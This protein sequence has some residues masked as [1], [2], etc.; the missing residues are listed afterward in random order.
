MNKLAN[1]QLDNIIDIIKIIDK[2]K[3]FPAI[4]KLDTDLQ[5]DKNKLESLVSRGMPIDI[6]D[7]FNDCVNSIFDYFVEFGYSKENFVSLDGVET[8]TT[9]TRYI[10][11]ALGLFV[12]KNIVINYSY[13]EFDNN[14]KLIGIK[15]DKVN[16]LKHIIIHETLHRLST[17]KKDKEL[18]MQYDAVSEGFTDTLAHLITKDYNIVSKSYDFLNRIC[19][20]FIEMIGLPGILED[21][22]VDLDNPKNLINFIKK[23]NVNYASFKNEFD[24]FIDKTNPNY[25]EYRTIDKKMEFVNV[26][27]NSIIIPFCKENPEKVDRIVYLF[28]DL[29]K[30]FN[31]SLNIEDIDINRIK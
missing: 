6:K 19:Y 21:Y 30:D 17:Y 15:A 25:E 16:E 9:D 11:K 18:C 12:G 31:V 4:G 7:F 10:H 29:F 8:Y 20:M 5:D 22:L 23:Y 28:N 14:G 27:K 26:F 24:N 13:F 1:N 2:L 3:N